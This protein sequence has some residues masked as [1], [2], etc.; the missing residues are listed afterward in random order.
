MLPLPA[1]AQTYSWEY[2][3]NPDGY[4]ADQ[5]SVL[6]QQ[7]DATLLK[8]PPT[9]TPG[10]ERRLALAALDAVT[11]EPRWDT[12]EVMH[13]FLDRRIG[14]VV[15]ALEAPAPKRGF[16]VFKLYNDSFIVRTR[17]TTVG[18]DLCGTRGKNRIIPDS[19]LQRIVGRCDILLISHKDPDHAD[20]RVVKMALEQGI[21]VYGP[22]DC[23]LQGVQ[24]VRQADFAT[25][26]LRDRT[27]RML[28][29]QPLPV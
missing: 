10:A 15:E 20:R 19:L 22:E 8:H 7:I 1:A 28:P 29:V 23:T 4:L 9:A 24:H 3:R 14:R 11:H 5:T 27:G 25:V 18:F 13:A 26:R 17:S 12:T 6:L 2:W 21:P 16:E